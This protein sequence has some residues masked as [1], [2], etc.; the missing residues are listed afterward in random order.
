M[1]AEVLILQILNFQFPLGL[2]LQCND[3]SSFRS[4]SRSVEAPR[5][6]LNSRGL[7]FQSNLSLHKYPWTPLSPVFLFFSLYLMFFIYLVFNF[8][9]IFIICYLRNHKKTFI[10]LFQSRLG[11]DSIPP[12]SV[13]LKFSMFHLLSYLA[14]NLI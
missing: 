14:F 2:N 12:C 5:F 6:A 1:G 11:P 13:S 8:H 3:D 4:Q 10:S 9:I 7:A